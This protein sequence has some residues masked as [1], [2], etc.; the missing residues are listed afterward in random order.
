MNIVHTYLLLK[1]K[2]SVTKRRH[3]NTDVDESPGRKHTTSKI[4][5][6]LLH[7]SYVINI[8]FG[9]G[10]RKVFSLFPSSSISENYN[11]KELNARILS[12]HGIISLNR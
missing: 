2:Q 12:V 1:M 3:L 6:L 5:R 8:E 4:L 10:C 9:C 7:Q 11:N